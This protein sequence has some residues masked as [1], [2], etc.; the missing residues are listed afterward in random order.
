MKPISSRVFKLSFL[1]LLSFVIF[2]S[3]NQSKS[4]EVYI[5]E[6]VKDKNA[7]IDQMIIDGVVKKDFSYYVLKLYLTLGGNIEPGGYIMKK[8]MGAVSTILAINEPEYRYVYVNE[9]DR[10]GQIADKLGKQLNW[11]DTEIKMFASQGNAC[12]LIGQEGFLA[13]GKYL[14]HKDEDPIIVKLKMQESYLDKLKKIGIDDS[15]INKSNITTIASLI[16]REAYD[17]NDMRLISGIIWNRLNQNM[18]LQIDATLQYIKG[19]KGDWW[20]IPLP[21]DKYLESDLNT[22]QNLGLPNTPIATPGEDA[23]LAA[24][25]PLE[26]DCLYYIH[27]ERGMIHCSTDYEGHKRNIEYYLK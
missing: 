7:V 21:E 17:K 20:P 25:N 11:A 1:L 9:G 4:D 15:K 2:H 19:E 12:K 8:G 26:T 22:Y 14:I 16:Q 10:K 6:E 3:F 23:L 13:S 27:D 24:V 18:P 5:I